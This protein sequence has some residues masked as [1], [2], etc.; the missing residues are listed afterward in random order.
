MGL[1][2]LKALPRQGL[3]SIVQLRKLTFFPR[4]NLFAAN[5]RSD[6]NVPKLKIIYELSDSANLAIAGLGK[7]I[8]MYSLCS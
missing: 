4:W 8:G 3:A 7:K 2:G 1:K 5:F 6:I